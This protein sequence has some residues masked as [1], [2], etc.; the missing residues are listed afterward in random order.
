MHVLQGLKKVLGRASGGFGL[1]SRVGFMKRIEQITRVAGLGK[2]IYIVVACLCRTWYIVD[3]FV[4]L[5]SNFSLISQ[6]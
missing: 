5:S 1:S 3:K 4:I 2:A 6:I